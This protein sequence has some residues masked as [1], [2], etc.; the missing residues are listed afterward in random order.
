MDKR[1]RGTGRPIQSPGPG[2]DTPGKSPRRRA[3]LFLLGL[4]LAVLA[5]LAFFLSRPSGPLEAP[6]PSQAL[7]AQA[8]R[9]DDIRV[10]AA[11]DPAQRRLTVAQEMTL[12][13]RGQEPRDSLML[14]TFTNAFQSPDTSPAASPELYEACYPQGFSAGSLVLSSALLGLGA[15]EPGPA[16]YRYGDEAKTV[17]R[18]PLSTLWEPG[19]TLSLSLAYTLNI[20]R[21]AG[22]FGENSGLWALGNAIPLPA[23]YQKGA[24]R[25]DPYYAVGDPFLSEC[26]N[27]T[28]AL[29]V[30][31]G[32]RAVGSAWPS[33]APLEDGGSLY[34]FEAL[35]VRDFALCLSRDYQGAQ[36]LEDGVLVSVYA[37]QSA[38]AA[39]ALGYARR[40]LACYREAFGPYPYPSLT[41]AE[42][43]FPFGGMEYPSLIMLGSALLE[44]GGQ[45]LE[46]LVAHEVAH[47]WWYGVVGSDQVEHP[48][49]D[50]AL[51]EY[52]LLPYMARYY[53]LSA[54]EDLA[55]SRFETA[56]RL[57]TPLGITPGS[58]LSAF[59]DGSEYATMVYGRGAA[60]LVALDTALGGALD[61]FLKTYYDRYRF[62]LATRQDFQ[63]AL[64]DFSGQDWSALMADYLDTFRVQ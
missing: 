49:Q 53:G 17:L 23:L 58:P 16:P 35:S 61:D 18:F 40:A 50:E 11:F 5:A 22:R 4:A 34:S 6:A 64:E 46:L 60:F 12:V 56:M 33:A 21:L 14:R 9:L 24:Y 31:K 54:R 19:Q 48:W 27:F 25:E 7:V 28:V 55:F 63:R 15:A 43:D 38:Q 52:S 3:P 10:T 13:N 29:T 44:K 30:P 37:K 62:R 32:Y 36:A 57:T 20:P 2:P 45:D 51:C 47:Q 1:Q 41:L 42:I 8:Q 59:A 39:Q 26:A